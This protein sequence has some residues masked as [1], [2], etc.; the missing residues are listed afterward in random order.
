[1]SG[2]GKRRGSII[3]PP[4]VERLLVEAEAIWRA[5]DA[6]VVTGWQGFIPA[7]YPDVYLA[8]KRLKEG[9]STFLEWGSGIGTVAIMAD[10]LGYESYGI[11]IHPQ[12]VERAEALAARFGS[13]AQFACGTFI[14]EDYR[15]R[16]Q[17]D[18]DDVAH[19]ELGGTPGYE[20]IGLSLDDFDVV[21]GYPWPGEEAFFE[22]VFDQL[23][24]P[25]AALVCYHSLDHVQ[26]H[27]MTEKT[28]RRRLREA[29]ER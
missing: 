8:L 16:A 22:D 10:M 21:Y 24:R 13:R 5:F 23:G 2:A 26:V 14:P 20:E 11:E 9:A 6:D 3:L 15:P 19:T 18:D 7:V 25:D 17:A 28:R 12:L 29:R 1:M 27:R 4:P